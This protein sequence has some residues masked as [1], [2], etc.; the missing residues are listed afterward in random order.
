M[1]V[2]IQEIMEEM[3]IGR[4]LKV[5]GTQAVKLEINNK[6]EKSSISENLK[7]KALVNPLSLGRA[8]IT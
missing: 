7:N 4:D 1:K 6:S 8:S 3:V 2:E 5:S